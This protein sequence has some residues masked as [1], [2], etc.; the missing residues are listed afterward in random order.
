MS[1]GGIS[2]YFSGWSTG[3][4]RLHKLMIRNVF[5]SIGPIPLL[6]LLWKHSLFAL[7]YAFKRGLSE[8][9]LVKMK[10]GEPEQAQVDKGSD[11]SEFEVISKE[12]NSLG[13]VAL[14]WKCRNTLSFP[15]ALESNI[16]MEYWQSHKISKYRSLHYSFV[17]SVA[18]TKIDTLLSAIYFQGLKMK[19]KHCVHVHIPKN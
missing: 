1:E 15:V 6:E 18:R 12:I 14:S 9:F 3:S 5:W 16:K 11:S 13:L 19:L 7:H 17:N 4:V 10:K 8:T 2:V